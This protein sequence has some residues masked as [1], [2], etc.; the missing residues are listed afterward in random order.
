[1][2]DMACPDR[3]LLKRVL[4]ARAS[5]AEVQRVTEHLQE[6]TTCQ[7]A[8]DAIAQDSDGIEDVRAAYERIRRATDGGVGI[9]PKPRDPAYETDGGHVVLAGGVR[10]EPAREPRYI[11]HL[12]GFDVE[13]VL[14][15]GA[16][17]VVLKAYQ[18]SLNR[19]V[20]VKV[21]NAALAQDAVAQRR[22]LDEARHA[23]ELRHPNIASIHAVSTHPDQPYLV[24]EY[25]AGRSLAEL[26]ED[27]SPLAPERAARI[28]RQILAGLEHAHARHK[29]HRDIKPS[30]VLLENHLEVAKIVDFGLAVGVGQVV[31]H[32]EEGQVVGTPAYMSPEQAAGGLD[33]DTRTDL[34]SVG[35]MLYEMLT[36]VPPF[37]ANN[38]AETMRRV[39]EDDPRPVRSLNPAVPLELAGIV[40]RALRKDIRRRYQTA[41]EFAADLDSFVCA[42]ADVKPT[43]GQRSARKT[44]KV[45]LGIALIATLAWLIVSFVS[46]SAEPRVPVG[47]R[48]AP[49][50]KPEPYTNTGYALEVIHEKTGIEMVFIPAGDFEMGSRLA[51]GDS[52]RKYGG[53]AAWF[54]DERPIHT[55]R[56][57]RP[58]Y[59]GKYE[60]TQA[61]W[62]SVMRNNP[63]EFSGDRSPVER[64]SRDVC[65]EFL[66][67][68]GDG[69]G[70]ATEAEWE[71]ACRAGT[72]TPYSF[73]DS[74]SRLSS[75]AWFN[76]NSGGK[77]QP[78]GLK[79][80]NAW[81]VYDMHGN[82]WEW[83]SDS[84][85]SSY[86]SRSPASDPQGPSSGSY[87]ALRGGSWGD[88]ARDCRS[89][90]RYY[91]GIR[92]PTY[93]LSY[94]GLRVARGLGDELHEHKRMIAI[95]SEGRDDRSNVAVT[96][97]MQTADSGKA[98]TTGYE[99][100][101]VGAGLPSVTSGTTEKV[102]PDVR[103]L[104]TPL[105]VREL[106]RRTVGTVESLCLSPDESKLYVGLWE[107][108]PDILELDADTLQTERIFRFRRNELHGGL[109]VSHDGRWAY[110]TSY[111]Y[112]HITRIDL[113]SPDTQ[114]YERIDVGGIPHAVWAHSI[115]MAPDGQTLAVA[116]GMD[117]RNDPGL[118]NDQLSVIDISE[119]R[120]KL[121]VEIKLPGEPKGSKHGFS[122]DGR[123]IYLPVARVPSTQ[124][125]LCEV[126][127]AQGRVSRTLDLDSYAGAAVAYSWPRE[128]IFVA[129][130][131][132]RRIFE[133]DVNSFQVIRTMNLE[134]RPGNIV[135]VPGDKYLCAVQQSSPDSIAIIDV[136]SGQTIHAQKGLCDGMHE[137]VFTRD[138]R[139]AYVGARA[140]D[141]EL[142]KLEV[143]HG[144]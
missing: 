71:Y 63:S 123:F 107:N 64:V 40:E 1:M 29:V 137:M 72:T 12:D 28:A 138:G 69:L 61:E 75:H 99:S 37:H 95:D 127:A 49:G 19:P 81:G 135:L 10:L 57:T 59:I 43:G 83:C 103:R 132:N 85:D 7:G 101:G 91:D 94:Y 92:A 77:A 102:L 112:R 114:P 140:S 128:A 87:P 25:V 47:F 3:E 42:L 60:V 97:D 88:G 67:K 121:A 141:G 124:I 9:P 18:E 84:Y 73:G 24:M 68:A 142:I 27:E 136:Q 5:P 20:A 33:P 70:L 113:R 143:S 41:G 133:V 111:H 4:G 39:R 66:R 96:A 15:S 13:R 86:Y 34:F 54:E 6:C 120:F 51:P 144:E 116:V 110:T 8:L 106:N 104:P 14:G 21:M 126:D 17:G 119:N 125:V 74:A 109:A 78:V 62:R 11:A 22:F 122:Q 100:S 53:Q 50:T 36:G 56:I 80:P 139:T 118:D 30:N 117:G 105:A 79:K 76:D 129:D 2:D 31:R 82:V 93:A 38:A 131:E 23:A 48:A 89:A 16:M 115:T 90:A 55:V 58:F 35:V 98:A 44:A 52:A 46:P 26:I 32:T 65:Q 130:Q 45:L 108:D 134:I